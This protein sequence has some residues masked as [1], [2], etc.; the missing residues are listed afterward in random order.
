MQACPSTPSSHAPSSSASSSSFAC[1]QVRSFPLSQAQPSH[2]HPTLHAPPAERRLLDTW[3][4]EARK[5]G[6]KSHQVVTWVRRKAGSHM[7]VWRHQKDGTLANATPCVLCVRELEKFDLKI[8]CSQGE[9]EWFSG[10]LSDGSAPPARPTTGQIRAMFRPQMMNQE[11][12]ARVSS[13]TPP[14]PNGLIWT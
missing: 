14:V 2:A 1:M 9:E 12:R 11:R 5:Q 4:Q 8:H 3:I 6:K 7:M 13:K 10:R